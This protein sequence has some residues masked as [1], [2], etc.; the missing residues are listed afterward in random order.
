MRLLSFIFALTVSGALFFSSCG[1]A[2]DVSKIKL[3]NSEVDSVSY[4]IGLLL[5]QN[6]SK[7]QFPELNLEVLKKGF[8]DGRDTLANIIEGPQAQQ[9]I[10]NYIK[11]VDEEKNKDKIAANEAFINKYKAMPNVQTTPTGLMYEVV[12]EGSGEKPTLQSQ[13]KVHYTGT[14]ED[15]TK[16]DSSLDRGEPATFG[17]GQVI[18]GW[19]EGLQ[20]MTPGSKYKFYIPQDLGYG[21]RGSG[22][23]IPPYSPLIFEVELLEIV[24]E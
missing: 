6:V 11:R 3:G 18:P 21:P 8:Y 2:Q 9:I 7:D 10:Q 20:L 13:V 23:Q 24:T 1:G 5:S 19:T 16:F 12:T 17:V 15:G 4:A 22:A 14:L